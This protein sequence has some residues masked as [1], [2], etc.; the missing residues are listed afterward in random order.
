[1]HLSSDD[2]IPELVS[3]DMDFPFAG[4]RFPPEFPVHNCLLEW[5]GKLFVMDVSESVTVSR[6]IYHLQKTEF[7]DD[8][9]VDNVLLDHGGGV[10]RD[11]QH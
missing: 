5:A 1:M 7:W 8:S 9:C 6:I 10:I 11:H 4:P 3:N 2:E